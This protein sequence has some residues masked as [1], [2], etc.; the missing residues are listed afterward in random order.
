MIVFPDV[1]C[2]EIRDSAYI[3]RELK[4]ITGGTAKQDSTIPSRPILWTR[5][6]IYIGRFEQ[7]CAQAASKRNL[8]TESFY[9]LQHRSTSSIYK[10][11]I[12]Y[13]TLS[14]SL[15]HTAPFLFRLY[16]FYS[17]PTRQTTK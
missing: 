13:M 15:C 6:R 16:I 17:Y 5:E 7:T 9:R 14:L 1:I 10:H 3:I 11:V 8:N 12:L 4:D 2:I